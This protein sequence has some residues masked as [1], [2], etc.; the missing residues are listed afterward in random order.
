MKKGVLYFLIAVLC[1]LQIVTLVRVGQLS[2]QLQNAQSEYNQR[3]WNIDLRISQISAE[4]V[5]GIE[6]ASS[7]FTS[8]SCEYG[9]IGE[10]GR[11]VLVTVSATPKVVTDETEVLFSFGDI[12][13]PLTR[14]GTS[15]FEATFGV[16]MFADYATPV[17]QIK[18][19]NAVQTETA[20][21]YLSNLF[22]KY[23]PDL[24]AF[25]SGSAM[26]S[27]KD[28]TFTMNG[29]LE[30]SLYD[31]NLFESCCVF[32]TRGDEI[33]DEADVR[34]QLKEAPLVSETERFPV[35]EWKRQYSASADDA[36]TL[37]TVAQDSYGYYHVYRVWG[38]RAA[39][40]HELV[41]YPDRGNIYDAD[42]NLLYEAF[43][44]LIYS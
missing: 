25:Y 31:E 13:M 29:K 11:K 35:T 23:L 43:R 18:E 2:N 3:L 6:Q 42:G 8:T 10:G 33:V 1:V 26:Y 28:G 21:F 12:E 14:V 36:F 15:K 41:I 40:D 39:G 7:L 38:H 4:I 9:G 16:D 44:G 17:L 37:Y 27:P 34:E 20:D 19:G 22:W 24:S 5:S 30:W 32:V